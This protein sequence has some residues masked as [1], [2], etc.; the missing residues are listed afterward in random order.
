I[1]LF[2]YNG[3]TWNKIERLETDT[4]NYNERFGSAVSLSGD[5]STIIAGATGVSFNKNA[6]VG[7]VYVFQ[8]DGNTWLQKA[9]VFASKKARG[10]QFGSPLDI[11]HDG[12]YF[13]AS[14]LLKQAVFVFGYDGHS[15]IEQST[16]SAENTESGDDFGRAVS[17]SA[18]GNHIVISSSSERS[19]AVGIN[20][21]QLSNHYSNAGAAYLFA[22]DGAS[23]QQQAYLKATNTESGDEFGHSVAISA[24]ASRIVVGTSY[25]DSNAIGI[26]G[27][28]TSQSALHSG[29]VYVY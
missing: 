13:V 6:A 16:F 8:Q 20:G 14:S 12:N 25:E 23:W 4:P 3:L 18:D 5:G 9:E 28:Q 7:A 19:K 2:A 15:W 26:N 11:S 10:A 21:D 17:M 24:D 27:D 29:A 1:Y 22:F